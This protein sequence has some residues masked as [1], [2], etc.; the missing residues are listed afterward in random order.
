[1]QILKK[2]LD[3]SNIFLSAGVN[4][5]PKMEQNFGYVLFEWNFLKDS[6]ETVLFLL[7]ATSGQN[8]N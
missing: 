1:M 5:A 6:L 7:K 4:G 2:I 8:F 3:F